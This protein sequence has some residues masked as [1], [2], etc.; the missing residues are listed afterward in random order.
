VTIKDLK[1][2][3][4]ICIGVFVFAF[5]CFVY[6][7]WQWIFEHN[8]CY[9]KNIETGELVEQICWGVSPLPTIMFTFAAI[10]I[11]LYFIYSIIIFIQENKK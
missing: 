6:S 2:F 10:F 4:K 5:D 3:D 1:I 8:I 9:I 7:G 11:T